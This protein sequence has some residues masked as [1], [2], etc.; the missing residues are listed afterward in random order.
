MGKG[1]RERV[2]ERGDGGKGRRSS[3]KEVLIHG[4]GRLVKG[5]GWGSGQHIY[6]KGVRWEEEVVC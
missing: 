6:M 5:G 4:E 3:L 2:G 1:E